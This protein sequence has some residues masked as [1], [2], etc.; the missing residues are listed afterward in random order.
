MN[1]GMLRDG[2]YYLHPDVAN[3][4]KH[5]AIAHGVLVGHVSVLM[6]QGKTFKQ[7]IAFL[8]KYFP[9]KINSNAVPKSWL[10][11]VMQYYK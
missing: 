8:S 5:V 9:E 6:A 4:Q 2:M 10:N 1:E 3:N 7:S 11:E